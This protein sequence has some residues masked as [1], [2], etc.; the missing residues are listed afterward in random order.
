M[1]FAVLLSV[2]S[3]ISVTAQAEEIATS[4]E[5]SC[6]QASSDLERHDL[7]CRDEDMYIVTPDNEA[8]D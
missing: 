1:R 3:L 7:G 4:R 2:L 6:A 8:N 5:N